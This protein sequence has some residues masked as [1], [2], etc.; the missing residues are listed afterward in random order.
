MLE[1]HLVVSSDSSPS[2]I[3]RRV[4]TPHVTSDLPVVRLHRSG[5]RTGLCEV[6]KS[7]NF[8]HSTSDIVCTPSGPLPVKDSMLTSCLFFSVCVQPFASFVPSSQTSQ[9]AVSACACVTPPHFPY[10]QYNR[11][12]LVSDTRLMVSGPTRTQ[13]WCLLHCILKY[14]FEEGESSHP[15]S[16]LHSS[17]IKKLQA[18][19]EH[20]FDPMP[21]SLPLVTKPKSSI[22]L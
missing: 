9:T 1:R 2:H 19:Q 18:G 10:V 7:R 15:A 16:L 6:A 20:S 22:T 8:Q 5:S 17:S 3:C 13:L 21:P 14:L 4:E 11:T 12:G